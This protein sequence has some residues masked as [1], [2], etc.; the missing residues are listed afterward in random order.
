[1]VSQKLLRGVFILLLAG[2]CVPL[3]SQPPSSSSLKKTV[4]ID[5][6]ATVAG[7]PL[8]AGEYTLRVKGADAK[9]ERDGK[10]VAEVNCNWQT[11]PSKVAS[12]TL[13]L[14]GNQVVEFQE[15]G[16]TNLIEFTQ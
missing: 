16:T 3:F 13:E 9:F 14:N 7:K 15:G 12:D 8:K 1:M 11:A 10:V 4:T 6:D 5:S 2:A